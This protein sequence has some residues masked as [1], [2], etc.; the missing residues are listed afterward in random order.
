MKFICMYEN[1]YEVLAFMELHL[2][3]LEM[4][5]FC[6]TVK[7]FLHFSSTNLCRRIALTN[8]ITRY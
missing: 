4:N 3:A 2:A 6:T 5:T 1:M 8:D 7:I